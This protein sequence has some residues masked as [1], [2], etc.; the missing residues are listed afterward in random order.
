MEIEFASAGHNDQIWIKADDTYEFI[1]GTGAPL[2]VIPTGKYV[3]WKNTS[4]S[5][6]MVVL[7][8]DGA[9]EEKR[10]RQ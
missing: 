9:I 2:G 8:T 7:Y 10:Q 6:D 5:G 4:K 1:K 3:W